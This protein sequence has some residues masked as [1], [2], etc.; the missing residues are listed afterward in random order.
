M[1]GQVCSTI[2]L[3]ALMATWICR[4]PCCWVIAGEAARAHLWGQVQVSTSWWL[5]DFW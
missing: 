2:F 4:P 3:K 5:A 1:V